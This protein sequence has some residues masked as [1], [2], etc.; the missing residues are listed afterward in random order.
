LL[1]IQPQDDHAMSAESRIEFACIACN[2]VLKAKPEMAGKSGTC[3]KCGSPVAVPAPDKPPSKSPGPP[4]TERQKEYARAL[5]IEFA[6]TVT[7][8][9]MG[10]LIDGA[11]VAREQERY[12]HLDDLSNRES[13]AWQKM[14][15]EVLAEIDAEDCRV[16][17][18]EP[19]RI[20]EALSERGFAT[21]LITIP[22]DAIEDFHHLRGVK[23]EIAFCD[24]MTQDDMEAVIES[25]AYDIFKRKGLM[26]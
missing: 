12:Q 13:E 19:S 18:A 25:Y 6:E 21:I 9:E 2:A 23:F 5:D 15:E 16:S 1:G 22:W 4:A 11:V 14:R 7:R 17:K 10:D 3:P 24:G 26:S 8:R 20:I